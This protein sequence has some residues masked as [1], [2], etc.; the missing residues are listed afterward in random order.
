MSAKRAERRLRNPGSSPLVKE[1]AAKADDLK[2]QQASSE[3]YRRALAVMENDPAE[4]AANLA[5]GRYLCL[6]KG[7]WERG[8]PMLALGSDAALKAVA[9]MELRGA[10]SAEQQAAIGNAWWDAAET[11]QGEERDM[12]RLRAGLWYRQAESKLGGLAA[13]KIKQRMEEISKLGRE[14][15]EASGGPAD[16]RSPPLAMA[17]FDEKTAKQHQAAWAKHLKVPVLSTNT[18][19][20]RFVLIPP[21]EFDM[22]SSA[23]EVA[24]LLDEAKRDKAPNWYLDGLPRE[25]PRHRVK[26]TK[27]FYLGLCEVT[28]ADYE[29]VI[30]SNPSNFKGNPNLSGENVNWD[31]ASAFCRKLGEL[32]QERA[33]GTIYRLPTEAEW[34]YA[35]R[36]GTTTRFSFGDNLEAVSMSVWWG[37]TSPGRPQPAGRLRPNA[38]GLHDLHGNVWEWC[39]DWYANNYY[40]LSPPEDPSGPAT[41]K[42][43]VCRGGGWNDDRT[44]YCR[45]SYRGGRG[46][47]D[48]NSYRGF[49]VVGTIAP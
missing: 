48:R 12:L 33:S 25:A 22:G 10:N 13:L 8:V 4:P 26:I 19:G 15:P 21:G 3:E 46:P 39:Q 38:W 37:R 49:R 30:G 18:I 47:G 23:E 7:D 6:V 34:E 14:I 9:I 17:P 5:A 35:C 42:D 41:G 28:Q 24:R 29:R 43:R 31:E 16:L 1:L 32:P 44:F 2:K 27:P 45:A 11:R 36:A 20:M 40:E